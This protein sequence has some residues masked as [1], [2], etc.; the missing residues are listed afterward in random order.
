VRWIG[1]F[2]ASIE[3]ISCQLSSPLS[4]PA[5]SQYMQILSKKAGPSLTPP[6]TELIDLSLDGRRNYLLLDCS[7]MR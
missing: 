3:R 6:V 7:V 5:R 2:R 4:R 1:I